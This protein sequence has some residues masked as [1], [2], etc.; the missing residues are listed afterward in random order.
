MESWKRQSLLTRESC[1][2]NFIPLSS[3][4]GVC[5]C[6]AVILQ[7]GP[8]VRF[9]MGTLIGT[10]QALFQHSKTVLKHYVFLK[11]ER[12]LTPSNHS[13]IGNGCILQLLMPNNTLSLF[14]QDYNIFHKNK[15]KNIST[16]INNKNNDHETY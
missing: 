11:S 14:N 3:K 12:K 4:Q 1:G 6:V 13:F 9:V 10:W 2:N 16:Y 7:K 15:R 8:G 5:V